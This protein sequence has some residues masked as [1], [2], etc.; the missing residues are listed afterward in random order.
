MRP[1]RRPH[2]T[3]VR[4][5]LR[6][7]SST[8]TVF[9]S[10]ADS[11][12]RYPMAEHDTRQLAGL[13]WFPCLHCSIRLSLLLSPH[14]VS[15]RFAQTRTKGAQAPYPRS[16]SPKTFNHDLFHALTGIQSFDN[17]D[18]RIM[19]LRKPVSSSN[20]RIL[21]DDSSSPFGIW[22]E[23]TSHLSAEHAP[24]SLC[25]IAAPTSARYQYIQLS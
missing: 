1:R 3:A 19:L 17:S 21:L 16:R 8:F 15:R 13:L 22:V 12:A 23:H 4:R 10:T 14:L 11:L 25:L 20:G 5:G 6:I 18:C 2:T 24:Y 7:N 9:M